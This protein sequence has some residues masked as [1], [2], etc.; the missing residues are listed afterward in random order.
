MSHVSIPRSVH[1]TFY[2]NAHTIVFHKWKNKQI[3]NDIYQ[4]EVSIVLLVI[5]MNLSHVPTKKY[6][7]TKVA[8]IS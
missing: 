5:S 6:P 7:P 8:A 1:W 2:E 4:Y 3:L